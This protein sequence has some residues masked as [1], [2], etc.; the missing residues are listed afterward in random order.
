[1]TNKKEPKCKKCWDKGYASQLRRTQTFPDFVGDKYKE[2]V[3]EVKNYCSCKKGRKL[4][5]MTK[6]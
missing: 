3:K 4:R 6:V 1:M 5:L 2:E